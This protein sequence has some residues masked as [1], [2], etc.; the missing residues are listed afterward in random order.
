MYNTDSTTLY[1]IMQDPFKTTVKGITSPGPD[2]MR[3][4]RQIQDK[5]VT[6]GLCSDREQAVLEQYTDFGQ[7][8]QKTY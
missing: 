4:V 5:V 2:F 3:I 6:Y 8:H 7:I 1:N